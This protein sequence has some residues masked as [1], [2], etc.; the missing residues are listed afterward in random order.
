MTATKICCPAKTAAPREGMEEVSYTSSRVG[1][2]PWL[3]RYVD[4]PDLIALN[5]GV[6]LLVAVSC[7]RCS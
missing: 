4:G 3:A 7:I 5:Y 1:P 6:L 2:R